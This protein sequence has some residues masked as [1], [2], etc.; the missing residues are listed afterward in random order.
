MLN[1]SAGINDVKSIHHWINFLMLIGVS[2]QQRLKPRLY[3]QFASWC[4]NCTHMLLDLLFKHITNVSVYF[5][6]KIRCVKNV[7][8]GQ[9][10][11][12]SCKKNTTSFG[13]ICFIYLYNI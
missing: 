9:F 8:I 6:G 10:K 4:K 11:I 12:P 5:K 13:V 2:I 1:K 7:L 3:A